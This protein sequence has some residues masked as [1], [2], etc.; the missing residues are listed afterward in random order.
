[1]ETGVGDNSEDEGR[2]VPRKV[3]WPRMSRSWPSVSG[4]LGL[5]KVSGSTFFLQKKAKIVF[6]LVGRP[7]ILK[8]SSS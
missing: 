7:V 2:R 6:L 3:T 8:L 5:P 4:S 1:M